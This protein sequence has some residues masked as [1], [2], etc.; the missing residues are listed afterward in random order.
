MNLSRG[1]IF[2]IRTPDFTQNTSYFQ[3]NGNK[4]TKIAAKSK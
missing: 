4:T 1:A 2:S 3:A